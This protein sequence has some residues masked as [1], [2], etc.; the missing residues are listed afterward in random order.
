MWLEF[1]RD[2]FFLAGATIAATP[3]KATGG[4]RTT[5]VRFTCD[6]LPVV[7]RGSYFPAWVVLRCPCEVSE[8]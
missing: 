2:E 6:G 5:R 3:Q 8:H 7:G 4:Y 1:Q